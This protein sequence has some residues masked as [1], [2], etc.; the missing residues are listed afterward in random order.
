MA[1]IFLP[2]DTV[3]FKEPEGVIG[4]I[5][6]RSARGDDDWVL[7]SWDDGTTSEVRAADLTMIRQ[8]VE[9]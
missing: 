6:E 4:G 9:I 7:V 3:S 5:V 8:G 1:L 2:G